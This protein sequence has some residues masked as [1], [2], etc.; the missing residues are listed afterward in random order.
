MSKIDRAWT[1]YKDREKKTA[2]KKTS[3]TSLGL[4]HG[5]IV[6]L[7]FNSGLNVT[8]Q[9]SKPEPANATAARK[10]V[11][12][13]PVD[14]VLW[15]KKWDH[16]SKKGMNKVDQLIP[17]PWDASYLKEKEIKFLSFHR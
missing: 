4:K 10:D 2:I 13:D 15:T 12:E 14:V 8:E 3:R 9:E 6:Y 1:L 17:D 16:G 11:P 7:F 5:D